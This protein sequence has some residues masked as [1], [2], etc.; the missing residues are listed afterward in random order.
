[1]T[2]F[3]H[4]PAW[5]APYGLELP[6]EEE[7]ACPYRSGQRAR[8]RA[9][10]VEALP[11]SVYHRFM[12][13]GFRRSGQVLYQPACRSCRACVPLRVPTDGFVPNAS[14]RRCRRRN[15]DLVVMAGEA[16]ATAEKL[17]LYNR[18]NVEWHAG[19]SLTFAAFAEAFYESCVETI[20]FTYR[21]PDGELLAVGLCDVA[22]ESLSSVYFYFAPE[23]AARGLGTYGALCEIDFARRRGIPH[24]YLGYWVAD[25]GAMSYKANFGP[26]ELL[27]ADG[28]WGPAP[29]ERRSPGVG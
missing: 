13:A 20:E 5:P 3:C 2:A 12:D 25:C 26:H 6:F 9:F 4:Y 17:A 22:P 23:A 27:G 7:L 21:G 14:Q 24:Y 15:S 10:S 1:L 19:A 29:G 11:P 28:V 8:Y 18:Y 16:V